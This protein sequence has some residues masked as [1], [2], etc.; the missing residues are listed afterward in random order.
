MNPFHFVS[1]DGTELHTYRYPS[2]M[3]ETRAVIVYYHGH[4]SY[5][6]K[7]AYVAHEF[8]MRGYDFVGFD[9]R[10]HGRSGGLERLISDFDPV[11]RDSS[12]FARLVRQA[13]P[14]KRVFALAE[15]MGGLVVLSVSIDEPELFDAL[16][17]VAPFIA[18]HHYV[19]F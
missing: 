9:Q 18:P 15:S 12:E 5:C 7:V 3:K 10:G 4:A 16:L 11:K 17:L 13:Y 2:Q 1:D 8:A 19:P 6:G 14:G